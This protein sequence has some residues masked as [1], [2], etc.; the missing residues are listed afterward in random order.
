MN[1]EERKEQIEKVQ[2]L[3]KEDLANG[4]HVQKKLRLRLLEKGI[5][6]EEVVEELKSYK[7]GR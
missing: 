3:V 5:C 6:P 4:H 2:E 7:N 1:V